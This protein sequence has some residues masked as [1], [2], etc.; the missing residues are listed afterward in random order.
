[1]ILG[2]H[3]Q[4]ADKLLDR[5]LVVA[6]A[7]GVSL[8]LAGGHHVGFLWLNDTLNHLPTRFWMVMT[9]TGDTLTVLAVVGL[10][11]LRYPGLTGKVIVAALVG[12]VYTHAIKRG[13]PLDRPPAVYDADVFHLIGPDH[14]RGTFPSG[15]TVT[16]FTFA[17]LM[18]CSVKSR[19]WRYALLSWAVLA[20]LSRV[21]VGVHF[22]VDVLAGAAGGIVSG[23]LGHR[24]GSAWRWANSRNG[25]RW[26]T[27][28]PL[29]AAIQ[30][31]GH[32][33]GYDGMAGLSTLLALAAIVACLLQLVVLPN[34]YRP[35]RP[36]PPIGWAVNRQSD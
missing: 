12:S 20:G 10:L 15:H 9:H 19:S 18:I 36:L 21:A 8:F 28:L 16:A 5:A 13:F 29:L 7:L 31:I 11:S 27:L 33:G 2:K 34:T 26:L 24:W 30:L 1:M 25:A 22:P 3:P 6:L 14:K 35:Y 32:D 17:S 4:G 23:W